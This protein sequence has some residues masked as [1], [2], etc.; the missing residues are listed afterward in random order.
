MDLNS[1]RC[2]FWPD[3]CGRKLEEWQDK[4]LRDEPLSPEQLEWAETDIFFALCCVAHRCPVRKIK[5][6]AA[7]QL[8]NPFWDRERRKLPPW[9]VE[10]MKLLH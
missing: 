7:V 10:R 1:K 5:N 9:D 4:F 8:L 3:C 6:Y 2:E